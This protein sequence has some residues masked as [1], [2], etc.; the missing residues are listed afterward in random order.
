MIAEA[1]K[2]KNKKESGSNMKLLSRL[3]HYKKNFNLNS[4]W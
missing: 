4:S 2:L 3:K 1:L